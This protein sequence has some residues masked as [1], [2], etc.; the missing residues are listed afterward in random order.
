MHTKKRN[1]ST[2]PLFIST[3]VQTDYYGYPAVVPIHVHAT[4]TREMVKAIADV[5][6][7]INF[8]LLQFSDVWCSFSITTVQTSQEPLMTSVGLG[9]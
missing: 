4:P 2:T 5:V 1:P 7:Y 9:L 3:H 6:V 8:S